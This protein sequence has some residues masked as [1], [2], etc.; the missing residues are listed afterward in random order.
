MLVLFGV[1]GN[2]FK[3]RSFGYQQVIHNAKP[4]ATAHFP[5]NFTAK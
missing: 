1:A 5:S 3:G 4:L 2:S